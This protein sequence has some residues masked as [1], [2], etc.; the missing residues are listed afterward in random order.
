MPAVLISGSLNPLEPWTG[1]QKVCFTFINFPTITDLLHWLNNTSMSV[2]IPLSLL[3]KCRYYVRCTWRQKYVK[4]LIYLSRRGGRVS[5][6]TLLPTPI[7]RGTWRC[8]KTIICSVHACSTFPSLLF[9]LPVIHHSS[10]PPTCLSKILKQLSKYCSNHVFT[11]E[12]QKI[13]KF[14]PTSSFNRPARTR[15][16][17]QTSKRHNEALKWLQKTCVHF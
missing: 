13:V 3:L 1:P 10:S 6:G 14:S 9:L 7:Q 16:S 17:K 8:S 4:V 15:A 5:G 12:R 2:K 11:T